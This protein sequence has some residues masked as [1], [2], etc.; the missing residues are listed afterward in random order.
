[1]LRRLHLIM[2]EIPHMLA[3]DGQLVIRS[4]NRWPLASWDA[5]WALCES[6]LGWPTFTTPSGEQV[7]VNRSTYL[8]F[9]GSREA[10]VRLGVISRYLNKSKALEGPFGI[11]L[12]RRIDANLT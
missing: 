8:R 11:L 4:L 3:A 9:R 2:R 5:Y 6:D 7:T 10:S 12:T 1:H